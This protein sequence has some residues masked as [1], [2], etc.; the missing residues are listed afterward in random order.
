MDINCTESKRMKGNGDANLMWLLDFKVD[1]LFQQEEAN[2]VRNT[3]DPKHPRSELESMAAPQIDRPLQ[4]QTS[5]FDPSNAEHTFTVDLGIVD[6][7]AHY[8]QVECPV[9]A[10]EPKRRLA[11]PPRRNCTSEISFDEQGKPRCTY[12]ELIERALTE[13][14]GLT[15]SEI[16]Q[17]IS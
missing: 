13:S 2:E 14:G 3:L 9:S 5:I 15:V 17:W 4:T 10:T 7:V 11:P 1:T 16:Y 8:E 12:T 6:D